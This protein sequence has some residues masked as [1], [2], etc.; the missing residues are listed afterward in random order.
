ME[1]EEYYGGTYPSPKYEDEKRIKARVTITF[2]IYSTVPK[3][4]NEEEIKEDVAILSGIYHKR[5][6]EEIVDIDYEVVE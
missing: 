1:T 6:N 2:E 4:W 3:N 5:K